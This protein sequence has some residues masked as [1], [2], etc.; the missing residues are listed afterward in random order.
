MITNP[1]KIGKNGTLLLSK[2][3]DFFSVRLRQIW[4]AT[5]L[6]I[7]KAITNATTIRTILLTSDCS[8]GAFV[9]G[10]LFAL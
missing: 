2:Y 8:A 10:F 4:Y 1:A 3:G 5:V 6:K 7:D 9:L